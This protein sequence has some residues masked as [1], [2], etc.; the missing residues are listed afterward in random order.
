[1]SNLIIIWHRRDLRI[2]DNIAVAKAQE[3]TQKIV[4][5]FCLD[6]NILNQDNI[7]PARITYMIGCLE[8]LQQ[9]YQQLGSQLL[10]VEGKPETTI[11]N[12]ASQLQAKAVYWNKDIETYSQTRDKKVTTALQEK[13]IEKQSYWDRL[14]HHPGEVLTQS[15]KPYKVYTPFWKNWIQKPK[16]PITETP[17]KLEGLTEKELKTATLA[18]IIPLPTPQDLGL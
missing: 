3:K 2:S 9:T 8:E 5:I 16:P 15:D 4:G 6:S 1:M 17:E 14:L 13:G 10:I 18:G 7:A 11:P 12:L